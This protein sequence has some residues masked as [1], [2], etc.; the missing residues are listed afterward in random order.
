MSQ[1]C[2]GC[3]AVPL[4]WRMMHHPDPKIS[5]P[6]Q[7]VVEKHANAAGETILRFTGKL[8]LREDRLDW[9]LKWKQ[10]KM[11]F[12]PSQGGRSHC[13]D[14]ATA[15]EQLVRGC[16]VLAHTLLDLATPASA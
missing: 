7:G 4:L 12:V 2:V 5:G 1:G 9:P 8:A 16:E 10:P 11:I 6:L 3:Y 14:E 15:P 13:P